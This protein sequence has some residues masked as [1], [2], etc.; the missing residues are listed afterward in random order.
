MRA[1]YAPGTLITRTVTD[2][3]LDTLL[4]PSV[5][6]AEMVCR[7]F[8]M[9]AVLSENDQFVVPV[10]MLQPPLSMLTS[11]L[12]TATL[13]LAVP[14]TE[15]VPATVEPL[16][17]ALIATVGGIDSKTGSAIFLTRMA[18]TRALVSNAVAT[19][20][21]SISSCPLDTMLVNVT[22]IALLEPP[23]AAKISKLLNTC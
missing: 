12:A 13:S 17:G 18:E 15:T 21:K 1:R 3:V 11:T 9:A 16:T 10:A 22:V 4:D 8:G 23:A 7:P 6:R 19:S 14:V 2:G 20:L 5:A